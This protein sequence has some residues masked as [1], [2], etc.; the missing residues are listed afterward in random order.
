MRTDDHWFPRWLIA[1]LLP[2]RR[3]EPAVIARLTVYR[4][5][6]PDARRLT[7]ETALERALPQAAHAPLVLFRLFPLAVE[8]STAIAFGAAADAEA[9]R[10]RQRDALPNLADC[11]ACRGALLENGDECRQCG[12]PLWKY[13]WLTAE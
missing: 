13:D 8:I 1:A 3:A 7:L 12:N 6:P 10:K 4:A 2:E 9:A 5:Q 11:A